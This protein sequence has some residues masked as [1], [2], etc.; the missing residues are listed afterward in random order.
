V[1][2]KSLSDLRTDVVPMLNR[3]RQLFPRVDWISQDVLGKEWA[4]KVAAE[5]CKVRWIF[6]MKFQ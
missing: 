3:G 4:W 1:C 2:D 5:A 6:P